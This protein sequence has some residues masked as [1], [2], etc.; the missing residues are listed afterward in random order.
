MNEHTR[1][2]LNKSLDVLEAAEILL[3]S[4][5]TREYLENNPHMR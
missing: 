3:S 2:L 5:K 1:K 4:G